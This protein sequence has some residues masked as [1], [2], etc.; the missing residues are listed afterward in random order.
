MMP[1]PADEGHP[2]DY[3]RIPVTDEKAPKE[4]DVALLLQRLAQAPH[5][6]ALVFNCQARTST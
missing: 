2:I 4:Q 1:W 3:V 5:D 6:A